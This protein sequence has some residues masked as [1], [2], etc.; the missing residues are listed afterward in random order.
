MY[1]LIYY[2]AR[3]HT[4]DFAEAAANAVSLLQ[5]NRIENFMFG[6]FNYFYDVTSPF[7]RI[8]DGG[9]D[10]YDNG[11]E[12]NEFKRYSMYSASATTLLSTLYVITDFSTAVYLVLMVGNYR[13]ETAEI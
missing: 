1:F 3:L 9:N 7:N 4:D 12:V 11:N 2:N 5:L 13:L 8:I 10:M 6:W